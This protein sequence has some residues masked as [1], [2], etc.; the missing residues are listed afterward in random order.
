[1]AKN[2]VVV[3]SPAK[4]KTL[5]KY[6]GRGYQVCASVGHI[7]DLPKG[8]LGVDLEND[9]QPEYSVI[10]GKKKVIDELRKAAK[11]KDM[12]YLAPD[13]DREGEAIAWHI[14]EKIG[15]PREKMRRVLFNEITRDAV[16]EA[17]SKPLELNKDRYDAQQARRVLDRLV[18]YQVSPLLWKKVRRGLSAGRVQSVAVRIV[19]DREREIR[20]FKPVEYWS[21][22]AQLEG[23]EPPPFSARLVEVRGQ[24]LDVK[25]FR[26]EN[27]AQ[28]KAI[29]DAARS[30]LWIVKSVETKERRRN[31]QPPFITSRLQQEASRK[32]SFNPRRTMGIAQRLYEGVEL[33]P[34]G[35]VGLITYMRTDSTR[36]SP[37]AQNHARAHITERYGDRYLPKEAPVYRSRKQ[38]Q[39]AHEAI[40]PTSME[41]SPERVAPFLEREELALYTLIWNRFIAS[42]MAPAIYDQTAVDIPVG[43]VLFRANGQVMKFDGFMRV[44]IEG[45]DDKARE[46]EGG[47]DAES[48]DERQLPRLKAGDKLRLLELLPE[49][50]FTQPPPRFSQATLIKDMEEDGIGRPS[51]YASIL[52]VILEKQYVTE[53]ESRRLH[54]TEL[55]IL[56]TDLLVESFPDIFNVEFTAGMEEILDG[57]E[58]GREGWVQATRRFYE[59]FTK[60]LEHA[61]EHMRDV[62]TQEIPTDLTCERCG[63]PMV[64]KWGRRGEFVACK[65]YPECRNTK[66]FTRGEDGSIQIAKEE[67]IDRTCPKCGKP[68]QIRFGRFG[69]FVGCTGYPDCREVQP[70]KLPEPIGVKCPDCSV[71]D[72]VGKF[73]RKG[74]LFYSCNRY[75]DCKFSAWDRPIAEPC[76]L[77]GGKYLVEKVTKRAGAEK[78][79]PNPE[80]TFREASEAAVA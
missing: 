23:P 41:Y 62:K 65:N 13:P 68:M 12:I 49:Q 33:G 60:D 28:A 52:G 40:R 29:V 4:A 3:E 70:L 46:G 32:L 79:C 8:K 24:R 80:C 48:D 1:M 36:V 57:V 27:E 9:F 72:V 2:L 78:R 66:N 44:Y 54:P 63:S 50:H 15:A 61:D 53:D 16:R 69:R 30:A 76:P 11:G 56:V 67:T 34:D 6:L 10:T 18:G 5:S 55:G 58:E 47:A 43:D 42:Q 45:I 74:K 22:A 35:L 39:D 14:A 77:C 51:T 38:A 17:I 31:P 64:I 21:I 7:L 59:P 25:G 73:S 20:A 71:G 37:E 26:V 75:P 19:V